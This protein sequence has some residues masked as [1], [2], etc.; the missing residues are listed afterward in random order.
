MQNHILLVKFFFHNGK[1]RVVAPVPDDRVGFSGAVRTLTEV[2]CKTG[3][4][5]A[6]RFVRVDH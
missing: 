2:R 1:R 4:D 3:T 6:D 5:S